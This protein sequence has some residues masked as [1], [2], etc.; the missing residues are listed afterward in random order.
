MV[1][2]FTRITIEYINGYATSEALTIIITYGLLQV[3]II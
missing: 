1:I 2:C 3:L